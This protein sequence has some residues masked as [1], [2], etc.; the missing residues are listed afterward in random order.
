MGYGYL[1]QSFEDD[2]DSVEKRYE[3]RGLE[4]VGDFLD[5]HNL[6]RVDK[7]GGEVD[8]QFGMETWISPSEYHRGGY[9]IR[10]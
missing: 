2:D 4:R 10:F 6:H 8:N 5:P 9:T 1:F 3:D 7:V